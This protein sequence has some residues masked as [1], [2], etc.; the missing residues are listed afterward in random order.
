MSGM[1]GRF[2][3]WNIHKCNPCLYQIFVN[4]IVKNLQ[5]SAII[6]AV[7]PQSDSAYESDILSN[8]V[9]GSDRRWREENFPIIAFERRF[10]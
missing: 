1:D 8:P 4:T 10:I 6:K 2:I 5:P 7:I 9:S 3:V